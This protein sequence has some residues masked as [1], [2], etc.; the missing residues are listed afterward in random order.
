[1]QVV[2]ITSNK[3]KSE[4]YKTNKEEAVNIYSD[5]KLLTYTLTYLQT[6]CTQRHQQ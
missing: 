3:Y 2:K 4:L 6:N 1:M 5:V